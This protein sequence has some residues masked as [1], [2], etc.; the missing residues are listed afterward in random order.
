MKTPTHELD[1]F[2]ELLKDTL[3]HALLRIKE[4]DCLIASTDNAIAFEISQGYSVHFNTILK[5]RLIEERNA[6]IKLIT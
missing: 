1:E 6:I 2:F 3:E 5:Q 4:L